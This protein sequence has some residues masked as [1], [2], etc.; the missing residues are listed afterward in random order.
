[1]DCCVVNT[2]M[3]DGLRFLPPSDGGSA[4]RLALRRNVPTS[5][6]Q[7]AVHLLEK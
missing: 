7:N 3:L 5:V 2:P 1:M 4:C 6:L